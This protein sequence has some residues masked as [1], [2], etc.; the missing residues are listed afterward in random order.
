[1]FLFKKI[2]NKQFKLFKK[3]INNKLDFNFKK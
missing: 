2:K 1:M 3:E